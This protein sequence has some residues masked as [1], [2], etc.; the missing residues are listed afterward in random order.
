M[1]KAFEN[2]SSRIELFMEDP[3]NKLY[4]V[5]SAK[6]MGIDSLEVIHEVTQELES[7]LDETVKSLPS[8]TDIECE[9]V[10]MKVHEMMS[11]FYSKMNQEEVQ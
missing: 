9:V 8:M 3:E 1:T 2:I 6:R 7:I 5:S 4:V 11:L 10:Q